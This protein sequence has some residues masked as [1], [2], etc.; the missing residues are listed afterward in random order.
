[1]PETVFPGIFPGTDV[2]RQDSGIMIN[3]VSVIVDQGR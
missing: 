3:R 2:Q 1:M